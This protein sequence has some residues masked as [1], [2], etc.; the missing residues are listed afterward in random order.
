MSRPRDVFRRARRIRQTEG[1]LSLL[2][3]GLAFLIWRLFEYQSYHI[4]VDDVAALLARTEASFKPRIADFTF[5]FVSSNR[6]ADDLE[7]RG[8][9]FRSSVP[10]AT[11]GLSKGAIASCV[12]VG[13]DL[14]H[15]G[16]IALSQQA[17]DALDEPPFHVHFSDGEACTG[18]LWTHP[19]YQRLG[20][21]SYAL[22]E[23]ARLMLDKGIE[24]ERYA[25]NIRNVR[26]Y[27]FTAK[28]N[29]SV[30]AEG[31]YLRVLWWKHWK[32]KPLAPDEAAR[33][34]EAR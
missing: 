16:W 26:T 12:F 1:F 27:A 33:R 28:Y 21:S 22:T 8:L 14:A 11:E 2:R 9:E 13:Q 20:L 3:R 24:T 15:I 31:R 23:R 32:E 10:H 5:V 29:A 18:Q 25:V 7:T 30:C 6:E 34:M 17:K 4:F 19:Q